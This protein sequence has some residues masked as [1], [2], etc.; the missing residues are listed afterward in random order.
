MS[1]EKERALDALTEALDALP[2]EEQVKRAERLLKFVVRPP[3]FKRE[4]KTEEEL[5]RRLRA[6]VQG[7][8][9]KW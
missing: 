9:Q 5:V 1:F 3:G 7:S 6:M 4:V 2:P 8:G